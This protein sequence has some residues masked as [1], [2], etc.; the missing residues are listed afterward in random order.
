[1]GV[2]EGNNCPCCRW[3]P[4]TGI[5]VRSLR[6][7]LDLLLLQALTSTC[8]YSLKCHRRIVVRE[9]VGKYAA[10]RGSP[11][12]AAASSHCPRKFDLPDERPGCVRPKLENEVPLRKNSTITVSNVHVKHVQ[13]ESL[14]RAST[15]ATHIVQRGGV[16]SGADI[17]KTIRWI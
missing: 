4:Q 13:T 2:G 1:M 5:A 16:R 11:V 8:H 17:W 9:N 12:H 7:A 10:G 3:S 15:R 14:I 6:S